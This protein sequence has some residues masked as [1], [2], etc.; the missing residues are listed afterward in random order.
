MAMRVLLLLLVAT[1]WHEDSWH[2]KGIGNVVVFIT[3]NHRIGE[4]LGPFARREHHRS[5]EILGPFAR[6][7]C[8]L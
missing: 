8:L 6:N 1:E 3:R 4:I 7:C 5:G 2:S